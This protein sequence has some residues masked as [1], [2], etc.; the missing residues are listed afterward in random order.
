MPLTLV[1]PVFNEQERFT[2]HAHELVDFVRS[3]GPG[4]ELVL[5]DDGS[6]DQTCDVIEDFAGRSGEHPVCLLRRPHLGKGAAVRAGLESARTPLAAFCDID[7]ATPLDELG[8]LCLAASTGPVLV[9]AS[10]DVVS[11]ELVGR[12]SDLRE[13][14][15]KSYNRLLRLTVTPGIQDTQCGAK[16][17]T[18]AVWREVLPYCRENGFA[19]DAEAI[20]VAGRRG[21]A[22]WEMGVRW[23]HDP[24][25]R[26]RPGRDGAAML[27]AV[28]RIW[29]T[30]R[31]VPSLV[32]GPSARPIGMPVPDVEPALMAGVAV[33]GGA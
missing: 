18:M 15:G 16:A 11:T 33:A 3:F 27:R 9:A 6:T 20:A 28:P 5:V 21:I 7:L 1:V 25:S 14:L 12:E 22:V 13:L 8:R 31:R 2:E 23:T 17:A 29:N 30:L 10:R 19:W 32:E 24:R 4:S 26:V